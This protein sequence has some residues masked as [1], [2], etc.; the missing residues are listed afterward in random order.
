MLECQLSPKAQWRNN[1]CYHEALDLVAYAPDNCINDQFRVPSIE[2][3]VQHHHMTDALIDIANMLQTFETV[4]CQPLRHHH[5][6]Q[7]RD[8][9]KH[10]P[11]ASFQQN[12]VELQPKTKKKKK[13]WS[14]W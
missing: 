12:L 7:I 10:P 1:Q 9:R 6:Y 4:Y 13:L 3:T 11:N 14:Q 2:N 5:M 8:C